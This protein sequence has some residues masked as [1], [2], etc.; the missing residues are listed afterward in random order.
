MTLGPSPVALMHKNYYL[1]LLFLY[2]PYVRMIFDWIAFATQHPVPSGALVKPFLDLRLKLVH[3]YFFFPA[4]FWGD[5][6]LDEE[7][8]KLFRIDKTQDW[9]KQSVAETGHQTGRYCIS[10]FPSSR[11]KGR[12]SIRGGSGPQ[13]ISV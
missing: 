12:G 3:F 4:V 5:I 9:M 1:S 10:L 13:V 7:D 2:Q 11:Q 6:A 8:L